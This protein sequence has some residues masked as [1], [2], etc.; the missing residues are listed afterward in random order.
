MIYK[1]KR[2]F[3]LSSDPEC[4]WG[5]L[6]GGTPVLTVEVAQPP[7]AEWEEVWGRWQAAVSFSRCPL[8]RCSLPP[9]PPVCP[10]CLLIFPSFSFR[11]LSFFLSVST[12]P[13]LIQTDSPHSCLRFC[14]SDT[15]PCIP[16]AVHWST[17]VPFAEA[18]S[19]GSS[20][21]QSDPFSSLC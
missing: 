15:H 8:S 12:G 9:Q 11:S 17:S 14:Y 2:L 6:W 1:G 3:R 13:T 19:S 7:S 4:V 10:W 18:L 20:S 16:I 21:S 5:E